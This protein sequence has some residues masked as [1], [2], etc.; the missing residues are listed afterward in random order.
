MSKD[1]SQELQQ[2][3]DLILK[4]GHEENQTYFLTEKERIDQELA[5]E[6]G[7]L[8]AEQERRLSVMTKRVNDEG[9][10]QRQREE[11]VTKQQISQKKQA[12]LTEVMAM[13][14]EEMRQWTQADFRK[15]VAPLLTNNELS[16]VVEVRLAS[17]SQGFLTKEDLETFADAHPMEIDYQLQTEVI[18][19]DGGFVLSQ[20]GIDY[21]FLS[22]SLLEQISEGMTFTMIK[23]LFEDEV[24]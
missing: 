14:Q 4:T 22:S 2:M 11:L 9:Q 16:G 6:L 18:A 5:S 24:E 17:H 15:M 13:A 20:E 19:N 12:Y 3:V 7:Q 10:R 23:M 21:N 8:R 1:Y